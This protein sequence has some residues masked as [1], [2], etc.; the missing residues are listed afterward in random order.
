MQTLQGWIELSKPQRT[1]LTEI[2]FIGKQTNIQKCQLCH[3]IM[4]VGYLYYISLIYAMIIVIFYF[5]YSVFCQV[6]VA[7]QCLC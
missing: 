3:L 5:V 1:C 6:N 7:R 2:G 4:T